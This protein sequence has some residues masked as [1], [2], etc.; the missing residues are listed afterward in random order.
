MFVKTHGYLTYF[1][2]DSVVIFNIL[3]LLQNWKVI[4]SKRN[5]NKLITQE[6]HMINDFAANMEQF[7]VTPPPFCWVYQLLVQCLEKTEHEGG[8]ITSSHIFLPG[9]LLKRPCETHGS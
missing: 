3:K 2:I 6:H 4:G 1:G 9:E 8:L 5:I 7:I